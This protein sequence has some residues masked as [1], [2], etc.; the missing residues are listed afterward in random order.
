MVVIDSNSPPFGSFKSQPLHHSQQLSSKVKYLLTPISLN[1]R[2]ASPLRVQPSRVLVLK[3]SFLSERFL[4]NGRSFAMHPLQ[5][6]V[7]LPL[8]EFGLLN[9]INVPSTSSLINDQYLLQDFDAFTLYYP[10]KC[11]IPEIPDLAPHI[12]FQING[13][14]PLRTSAFDDLKYQPPQI[15]GVNPSGT[16]DLLTL[17]LPDLTI[18]QQSESLFSMYPLTDQRSTSFTF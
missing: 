18:V 4:R 13:C 6:T 3:L 12:R 15:S 2:S 1:L 9:Q 10:P 11:S 8:Q 5:S 14:R 16:S 17:V 7:L